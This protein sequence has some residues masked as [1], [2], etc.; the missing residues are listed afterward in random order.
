[1]E[2]WIHQLITGFPTAALF[3]LLAVMFLLLSKGADILVEESVTLSLKWGVS[4]LFIGVTLVSLGTTLPEVSVSVYAA[5]KGH[6]ELAMGNAV[7]SM[8][9]DMGLIL[10]L[11][12]MI[13]PLPFKRVDLNFPSWVL[14]GAALLLVITSLPFGNLCDTFVAGG[15]FPQWAGFLFLLLLGFYFWYSM[16]RARNTGISENTFNP[17]NASALFVILKLILGIALV[18]ISSRVLIPTVGELAVRFK[19]PESIIAATLV[20][21]GTSLPEL[22]TAITAARKGHG[23]LAIGNVLGAD[24]LNALLVAGASA[25]VTRGGLEVPPDFY[26]LYFPAMLLLVMIFRISTSVAETQLPRWIS[27]LFLGIY[28]LVSTI[29]YCLH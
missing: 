16:H 5:V 23:D 29:G 24:I 21:F 2:E 27:I 8:I 13:S 1:M 11:A 14:T 4:K 7:G 22:I 3:L 25:A 15:R 9:C 6:A 10:G 19:V 18:I 17:D 20:A 12:L 26:M 28:F